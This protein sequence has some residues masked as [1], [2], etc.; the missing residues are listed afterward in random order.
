MAYAGTSQTGKGR[1]QQD[2]ASQL[3]AAT[4]RALLGALLGLCQVLD[5]IGLR[6]RMPEGLR[7]HLA[8]A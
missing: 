3:L 1:P 6:L 2:A 8:D 4:G 5:L 7:R